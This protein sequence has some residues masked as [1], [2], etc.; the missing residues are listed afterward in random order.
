MV[1]AVI[2]ATSAVAQQDVFDLSGAIGRSFDEIALLPTRLTSFNQH[3]DAARATYTCCK[4]WQEKQIEQ[5]LRANA[6]FLMSHPTSDYAD[7][8][9]M[10]TARVNSVKKDFRAELSAYLQLVNRYPHSD[11]ADDACWGLARMYRADHDHV[12]AINAL[13]KLITTWPK[14]TWADDAHLAIAH[15]FREVDDEAGYLQALEGMVRKHPRADCCARGLSDL[16]NK[17]REVENYAAAIAACEDLIARYPYSDY[18]DDAL[19]CIGESLRHSGDPHGA[20]EAYRELIEG[21]PG[22]SLTNR[23]MR[24]ANTL[25]KNLRGAGRDAPGMYNTEAED[26][27]KAAQEM[28]DYAR[29][30]QNYRQFTSAAQLYRQ[31]VR[32]FPGSDYFDDAIFNIGVCYQQMNILFEDINK[33]EGP[34]DLYR[35][36]DRFADA[37][38]KRTSIPGGQHLSAV[39]DAASAFAEVVNNLIGSS[40]RDDALYEIAKTYEDSE[41]EEDMVYTYAQLVAGFPGSEYEMEALYEVL[42][43]FS[44]PAN[45]ENAAAMYPLLSSAFPNIFPEGLASAKLE[46]LTLMRAYYS[47]VSFAWFEYHEHHIPYRVTCADLGPDAAFYLA[48]INMSRGEW[49]LARKQLEPLLALRTND[50]CAPAMFLLAQCCEREGNEKRAGELYRAVAAQYPDSGL[51]DDA[52]LA[53]ARLG[54]EAPAEYVRA[55]RESLDYSP[56][57]VDCYVGDRIVIFAP[58]TVSAKMRQYN[59]PNI[60]EQSQVLLE[61]WTGQKAPDRIVICI[62]A[63]CRSADG[64]PMLLPGCKIADPPKWSLGFESLARQT[65]R[66]VA[67]DCLGEDA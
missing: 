10:H 28:F 26:A 56:G 66:R 12:A 22:S 47:H 38:G 6:A 3:D 57:N 62:D 24:E 46:F 30:L 67:G 50:F 52:Q 14:S 59:M 65:I 58:Y 32:T 63:G 55:V 16:A 2:C 17:Y 43:Y 8:T 64:N 45:Y 35:L 31:F 7:D 60:W 5:A 41:L 36:Q 4:P 34:E 54:E 11:M 40:L 13:N 18:L 29:H 48:A 33:A 44:N 1:L 27:G 20:L 15:E 53:I 19:F 61:E 21:L 49:K 51:A 37:I 42:K 39:K 23:A 9:L 25:A